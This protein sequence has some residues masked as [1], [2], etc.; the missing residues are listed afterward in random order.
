MS[1]VEIAKAFSAHMLY[2][3]NSNVMADQLLRDVG[4]RRVRYG[5]V[6]VVDGRV[7]GQDE[8]F[9]MVWKSGRNWKWK[10]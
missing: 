4:G 5:S 8:F 3:S 10:I 1:P 2:S 6:A 7:V 9:L